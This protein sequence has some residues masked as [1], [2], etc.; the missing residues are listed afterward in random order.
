MS[1]SA[2]F[3]FQQFSKRV[4]D[5]I[6][7]FEDAELKLQNN[8]SVLIK[9]VRISNFYSCSAISLTLPVK[10]TVYSRNSSIRGGYLLPE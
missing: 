6:K 4:E 1:V 5:L 9:N 3:F 2:D 8:G 7:A 10:S